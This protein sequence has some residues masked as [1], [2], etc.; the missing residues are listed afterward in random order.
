MNFIKFLL[1]FFAVL[2]A[3]Y[4]FGSTVLG[5]RYKVEDVSSNVVGLSIF[6]WWYY[7][8]T[9][10]NAGW[11]FYVYYLDIVDSLISFPSLLGSLDTSFVS[12]GSLISFLSEIQS[13]TIINFDLLF[14]WLDT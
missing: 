1:L 13:I 6:F 8:N 4:F 9:E 11:L 7:C 3:V 14:F 2:A 12:L 10:P 5:P